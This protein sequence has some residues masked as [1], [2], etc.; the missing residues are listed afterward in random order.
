MGL[1]VQNLTKTYGRQ[2]LFSDVGFTVGDGER[3]G[4]VGRN[5]AG[6]T[7]LFRLIVGDE[8]PDS[9]AI[10]TPKGYTIGRLEQHLRFA[11]PTVR[12]E[13]YG[14][15]GENPDGWVETYRA[16]AILDGLGFDESQL[17][18]AP[19]VLSG[20]FQVRLEL[21]RVLLTDPDLLLLDEPTNYLDIVSIRWLERF[22]RS[23]RGEVMLI[24]HD[25]TFMDAVT[26]HT[27]AIH[28][29]KT[30]KVAG[31]T[32]KLYD[33][34]ALDE[35]VYAKTVSNEA[36]KREIAQQFIDRFRYKAT[37]AR[38][39][40]SRIKTLDRKAKL[41]E[42]ASIRTLDFEFSVAPFPGK[43]ITR[44][45]QVSFGYERDHCLINDL[46]VVVEPGE[47]IGVVGP[48]GRGKTTLLELIAGELRPDAGEI[49][50]SPNA[51]VGYFGQTNV[52]RLDPTKTVEEEIFS[53]LPDPTRGRARSLAGKMMFEGDAALKKISVLSGGERSR[54][55]LAQILARPTNLLLL[56]EPSNHLDMDSVQ[57]LIDA[58]GV[59]EGAVI[60]V[61]HDEAML[62]Q[63][64]T[65][66]VVFE[67]GDIVI[68]DGSYDEFL[69]A[70]GWG[71]EGVPEVTSKSR[72]FGVDSKSA[73]PRP[74]DKKAERRRRAEERAARDRVLKPLTNRVARIERE[75]VELESCEKELEAELVEGSSG[76]GAD[77]D[78]GELAWRLR[79]I[80]Q[81]AEQ[82]YADLES[83]EAELSD[84]VTGLGEPL[85]VE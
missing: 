12:E 22:L 35:E 34:I 2:A 25:R 43:R 39:V 82:R 38:Q 27:M 48:N 66:L 28:R 5:G 23:W 61:T 64:V 55:L 30:R 4:V 80:Q 7:T 8:E 46:T 56:D 21:A 54:V 6:K 18:I 84:R 24:T 47:C 71:D 17:D 14:A 62:R 49:V 19:T 58:I 33:Q 1:Q 16:D 72:D 50:M 69:A 70:G 81:K 13:A 75:I 63:V 52:D 31:S 60:V 78:F 42:L 83:A 53:A 40:Q 68:F 29:A 57:T 9:G 41:E 65:R 36:R 3:L 67:S 37:K 44:I 32:A 11:E 26:T 73:S 76:G 15:L 20:G 51:A 10:T 79:D 85:L 74:V 45:D 59:F 77:V